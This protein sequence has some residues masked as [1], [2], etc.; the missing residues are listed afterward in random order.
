MSH[1]ETKGLKRYIIE[2]T[3][4]YRPEQKRSAERKALNVRK[5]Y[6]RDEQTPQ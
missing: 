5:K 2:S 3:R 6:N 4:K 1:S